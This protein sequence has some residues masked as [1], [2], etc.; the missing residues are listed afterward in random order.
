MSNLIINITEVGMHTINYTCEKCFNISQCP[1]PTTIY[2]SN[3]QANWIWLLMTIAIAIFLVYRFHDSVW[4]AMGFSIGAVVLLSVIGALFNMISGLPM[5]IIC[6]VI[7]VSCLLRY[8]G[9]IGL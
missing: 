6:I 3:Y 5:V 2:Y 7:V 8:K 9:E 4:K 1:L